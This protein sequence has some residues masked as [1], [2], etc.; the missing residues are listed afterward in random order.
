MGKI[1]STTSTEYKAGFEQGYAAHSMKQDGAHKAELA[2]RDGE[3]HLLRGKVRQLEQRAEKAEA[4][5]AK[6][7]ARLAKLDAR[8]SV[9][10]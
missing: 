7:E 5:L 3:L 6:A 9:A 10:A 8:K 4:A 2:K 1:A